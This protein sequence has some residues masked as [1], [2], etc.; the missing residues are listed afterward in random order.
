MP[1]HFGALWHAGTQLPAS[2]LAARA[3]RKIG[4]RAAWLRRAEFLRA[5]DA[6]TPRRV[7]DIL[8]RAMR[9]AGL[10]PALLV[11]AARDQQVLEIGCGRHAG[12]AA[13]AATAG[14]RGYIGVD[15]S[16]ELDTLSHPTV[17]RRYIARALAQNAALID[18]LGATADKAADA[19]GLLAS[20][21]LI[22]GGIADIKPMEA[23]VGLCV[24]ISCLEHIQDFDEAARAIAALS[25]PQTTH[26]H[27]VNFS[28]H[29]SKERPFEPLYEAP[30]PAFTQRWGA[31]INGH[32]LPD[33]E[34][35]LEKAGLPMRALILESRPD[36]LP[37]P[38]DDYWTTRY[39]PDTLA[40][41]A[42]ILTTIPASEAP[43]DQ[44]K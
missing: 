31:L 13:F 40:V 27:L 39:S 23:P 10:D 33:L 5:S 16:L 35:A 12:F 14:A 38:I 9:R 2:Y 36:A 7:P 19:A 20:A 43:R 17:Q 44:A 21:Q 11:G 25:A 26:V 30:F 4:V 15:P 18:E 37:D 24:S 42:A 22:R 32:R 3:L 29:L 1:V 41:R 8:V 28:N 34:S 6:K